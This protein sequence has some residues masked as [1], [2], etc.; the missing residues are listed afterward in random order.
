MKELIKCVCL[1]NEPCQAR[2]TF[3][4]TNSNETVFCPFT[5]SV[6]KC[7]GSCNTTDDPYAR[8]CVPNKVTNLNVKVFNLMSGVNKTRFLVIMNCVSVNK[9]WMQVYIIQSR[10]VTMMN[11]DVSVKN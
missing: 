6:H 1:N 4:D 7:D 2:P 3:V 11:V 10:N 9:D 8:V 5:V